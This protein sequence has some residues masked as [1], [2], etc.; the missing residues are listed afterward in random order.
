M[1]KILCFGELLLRLSPSANGGWL[2]TH[3]MPVYLGGAELNVATALGKWGA[4]V[5]YCTA[6]PDNY[7]SAD[8][9]EA[10]REKN[11]STEALFYSGNRV[12]TY[13][14][15]QG[16]DVK[17]SGVIYDRDYSSFA[18]LKRGMLNWDLILKDVSWFHFSA[19][20]PA[21]NA[22]IAEVCREGLEAASKKN[23]TISVDLNHRPKLWKGRNPHDVMAVLGQYCDVI[24][25]NIWSA[26]QLLGIPLHDGRI[27]PSRRESYLEHAKQ[28][29]LLILKK[30]SRCKTVANTFRFDQGEKGI[31]YYA[32]LYSEGHHFLSSSVF[33]AD[34]VV[35][36][37]GTGDCFMAGLIL[38]LYKH[39]P[40]EEIIQ[41]AAAAAFGKFMEAGDA[42]GQDLA[43]IHARAIQYA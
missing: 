18:E 12:G 20:S 1:G 39:W 14:L 42:T 21:L 2:K 10:I 13:F 9:A 16:S 43:T 30:F 27:D 8:V 33:E 40:E 7:L 6:L 34:T 26:H 36:K 32:T 25:G 5:S 35:D 4:P 15:A 3:S 41:F 38:G 24:M 23:I 11:I 28:T 19:I 31:R 37:V 17:N 22:S 29:S